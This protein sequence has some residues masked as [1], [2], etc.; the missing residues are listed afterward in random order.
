[1]NIEQWLLKFI[2]HKRVRIMLQGFLRYYGPIKEEE[3]CTQPKVDEYMQN[4]TPQPED[5]A[6]SG[7]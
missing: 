1:M 5:D 3:R 7:T 2:Q 6:L 4:L